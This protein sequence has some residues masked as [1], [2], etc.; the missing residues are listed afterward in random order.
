MR[1]L[2]LLVLR[3][4]LPL[5]G[6]AQLYEARTSTVNFEKREREALQAAG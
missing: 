6:R 4:C 2:I 3:C 5:T 1:Y